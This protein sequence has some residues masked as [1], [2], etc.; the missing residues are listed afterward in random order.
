[1]NQ[2]IPGRYIHKKTRSHYIEL[3]ADGNYFLFE[4]P[5]VVS[6]TYEV[7]GSDITIFGADSSSRGT[8]KDGVITDSEGEKWVR[9]KDAAA[10]GNA[11]SA[12][13]SWLPVVREDFPW[14]LIDAGVILVIFS[15]LVLARP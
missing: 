12:F 4:G 13:P 10:S 14:E 6:G 3:K 9:A 1:M 7:E 8:I 15:L 11:A 5:T 2:D